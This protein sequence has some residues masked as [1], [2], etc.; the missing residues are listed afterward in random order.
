MPTSGFTNK[1]VERSGWVAWANQPKRPK[2]TTRKIYSYRC[3]LTCCFCATAKKPEEWT[4]SF[5][6]HYTLHARFDFSKNPIHWLQKE[7][8]WPWQC[9]CV[10]FLKQTPLMRGPL[11]GRFAPWTRQ[12]NENNRFALWNCQD[13]LQNDEKTRFTVVEKHRRRCCVYVFIFV[14]M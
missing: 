5:N 7:S 3:L 9:S 8:V 1:L 2:L 12:D 10:G 4:Q 6:Y 14:L 11:R 13:N